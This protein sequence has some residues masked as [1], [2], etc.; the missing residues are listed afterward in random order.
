MQFSLKRK[1][2]SF[3]FALLGSPYVSLVLCSSCPWNGLL[4]FLHLIDSPS[5]FEILPGEEK[6][7]SSS[8][9]AL[10]SGAVKHLWWVGFMYQRLADNSAVPKEVFCC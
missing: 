3:P 9:G 8:Y 5:Q 4:L 1:S 6:R 2:E 10:L 7:D